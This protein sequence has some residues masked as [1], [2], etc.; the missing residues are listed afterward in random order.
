M[1][2]LAETYFE[3]ALQSKPRISERILFGEAFFISTKN[4]LK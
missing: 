1:C 3:L 2:R 4:L